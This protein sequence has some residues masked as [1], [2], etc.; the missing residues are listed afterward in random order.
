MN[1]IDFCYNGW[2]FE[3]I[4]PQSSSVTGTV[5]NYQAELMARESPDTPWQRIMT[6]QNYYFYDNQ[7]EI[8]YR[9]DTR[10]PSIVECKLSGHII[11]CTDKIIYQVKKDVWT[12]ICY[13]A[14][15]YHYTLTRYIEVGFSDQEVILEVVG[16]EPK[17]VQEL[18]EIPPLSVNLTT[19]RLNL[20][21]ISPG[22]SKTLVYQS[23][24]HGKLVAVMQIINRVHGVYSHF[25]QGGQLSFQ[26]HNLNAHYPLAN[27]EGL[28][29][30]EKLPG[31]TFSVS[32]W[33]WTAPK[34]G[35]YSYCATITY[36]APGGVPKVKLVPNFLLVRLPAD[37][38]VALAPVQA[39]LNEDEFILSS[40]GQV[41]LNATLR[42]EA[43]D[44][45]RVYFVDSTPRTVTVDGSDPI[46][47]RMVRSGSSLNIS[48][49]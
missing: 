14:R 10:K 2:Y 15:K 40:A 37:E 30:L 28:F 29:A 44:Q 13:L 33:N 39:T 23:F 17:V 20:S 7:R 11:D 38:V 1:E 48:T 24:L 35:K 41:Q 3:E 45:L 6:P 36:C 32:D 9:V 31:T 46:G 27:D 25:I 47:Y 8:I 5:L 34:S 22:T 26:G 4:P 16:S 18:S 42:L 12:P 43:G 19:G 21:G 49:V